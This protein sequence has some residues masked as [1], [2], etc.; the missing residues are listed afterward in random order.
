MGRKKIAPPVVELEE[1][2]VVVAPCNH[3]WHPVP[4]NQY[5]SWGHT[6]E[7]VCCH[8]GTRRNLHGPYVPKPY[9]GFQV[10]TRLLDG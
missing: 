5:S 8:C 9:D 4:L 10:Q 6:S 2:E 1:D 3:C 7:E